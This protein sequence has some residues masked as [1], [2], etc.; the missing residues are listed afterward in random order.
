MS[1]LILKVRVPTYLWR[2]Y[3]DPRRSDPAPNMI[4]PRACKAPVYRWTTFAV[5]LP[6]STLWLKLSRRRLRLRL[7]RRLLLRLPRLRLLRFRLLRFRLL[8]R[9][10]LRLFLL[11]RLLLR[12]FFL[13][14]SS[15]TFFTTTSSTT[16]FTT[17]S[18]T[19][20]TTSSTT[21]FA[22]SSVLASEF[23]VSLLFSIVIMFDS[24]FYTSCSIYI[25]YESTVFISDIILES[26]AF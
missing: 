16:F 21:F 11:S 20:F 24:S 14:T 10:L 4:P 12:L 22:T 6:L 19:F 2:C 25:S 15:T 23:T 26:S 1:P 17:S 9:L 8:R 7:L 18:T 13:T 3:A 5:V